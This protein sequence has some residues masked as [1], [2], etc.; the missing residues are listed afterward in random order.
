MERLLNQTETDYSHR[1]VFGWGEQAWL[2]CLPCAY[3]LA[4]GGIYTVIQTKAKITLDEWGEN[5][6]LIG[7]YFEHNVKTQV[8]VCE[9]PNALVKKAM[10]A[11]KGSGCQVNEI[12]LFVSWGDQA[13]SEEIN[14]FS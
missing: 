12:F 4:V 3:S 2:L 1:M 13:D 5:Y 8:E 7:P 6:F 14:S 9:P 10:D 11:M